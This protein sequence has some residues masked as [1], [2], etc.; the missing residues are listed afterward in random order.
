MNAVRSFA[1]R[2]GV[3]AVLVVLAVTLGAST[4]SSHTTDL[5][6]AKHF[7]WAPGQ[8]PAGTV[9]DSASNDLIYHGGNAGAGAIGVEQKPAVYL[10]YWGPQWAEGFMTADTNGKLYSSK[11]LQTYLNSFFTNVGGS[12]LGERPDAVLQRRACRVDVAASAARGSS[13]TRCTSSRA[14]GPT[15]R[16]CLIDIVASG[17]AA[18]PRRRPDRARGDARVRAL[19]VRRAGDVH[20][21][22]AAVAR[23]RPASPSTAATTRRRRASTES[24]TRTASSTR[25]SRG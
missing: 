8:N 12:P 3:L 11:T 1:R 13:P 4:A 18:E 24:A 2:G 10:V 16:L 21:P 5:T 17:L 6:N 9:A 14:C 7:F 23:S 22:H 25:S 19:Q 15:R 20:H